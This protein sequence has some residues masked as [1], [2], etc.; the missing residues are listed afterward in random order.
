MNYLLY[1]LGALALVVVTFVF[2]KRRRGE[3]QEAVPARHEAPKEDVFQ[4]IQLR[5]QHIKQDT[6]EEDVDNFESPKSERDNRG[7]GERKHDQYASDI[8]AADVLAEADIYIAYGRHQQAID[9]LNNAIAVEPGSSVCRLKLL[10]IYTELNDHAAAT[11]QLMKIQ[12]S[13]DSE[14]I[15]RAES[16]IKRLRDE[17]QPETP[18]ES[19][20]KPGG[21]GPG[22]A[23]NPLKMMEDSNKTLEVDFSELEIEGVGTS[24]EEDDLDLSGDFGI[25]AA[26]RSENEELVIAADSNG[27]STKL[28][29]ARAY[30]DMGDDDGA[31]QILDEVVMEGS[32]ELKAEARALLD[33]IGG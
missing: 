25:A 33:R 31:R 10:E 17:G 27:L 21:Y 3:Q 4:D 16:F 29:L 2:S 24:G 28:D 23:P 11:S 20:R 1:I 30:L 8:D 19:V 12:A 7:Y 32:E 26:D 15:E 9:L 14:S 22:L 13:G 18:T 6:P 5:D